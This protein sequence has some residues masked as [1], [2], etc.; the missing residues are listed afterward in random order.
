[1]SWFR[2]DDEAGTNPGA[3]LRTLFEQCGPAVVLIDEWVAYAR[4]LRDSHEDGGRYSLAG[5]STPNS[6]FAQA[7]TEAAAS[8]SE[9]GSARGNSRVDMWK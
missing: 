6:P 1:M 7:L 9:R 3:A 5:T 4:Q 8:A 2:A